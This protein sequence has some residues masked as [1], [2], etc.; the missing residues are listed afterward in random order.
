ME[1]DKMGR[2]ALSGLT[3]TALLATGHAHAANI[4]HQKT[5]YQNHNLVIN[6]RNP[7]R[8]TSHHTRVYRN[9]NLYNQMRCSRVYR[10]RFLYKKIQKQD[11]NTPKQPDI[12]T[13]NQSRYQSSARHTA[14]QAESSTSNFNSRY[15]ERYSQIN[16]ILQAEIGGKYAYGGTG[17]DGFD[18]SGFTQ[19]VYKHGLHQPL[20]RT[21]EAQ[22]QYCATVDSTQARPG[23]LAFFGDNQASHV[24]IYIGNDLMVDAQNRGIVI[25]KVSAP[26]WHLMNFGRPLVPPND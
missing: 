12:P 14:Y 19:Y 5:D 6:L 23:D 26:W 20:P 7:Q 13:V 4:N 11:A 16:Q 21:A 10:N 17:S 9:H 2:L 3:M 8:V 25:E 24:G 15:I 18:C 22:R 1:Y